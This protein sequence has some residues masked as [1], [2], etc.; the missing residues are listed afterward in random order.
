[1]YY[2]NFFIVYCIHLLYYMCTLLHCLQYTMVLHSLFV[3]YQILQ[4]ILYTFT[5]FNIC[6]VSSFAL[7]T[8][9]INCL[10]F[11]HYYNVCSIQWYF[12]PYVYVVYLCIVY[13]RMNC[14]VGFGPA[15]ASSCVPQTSRN[16][17]N[18]GLAKLYLDTT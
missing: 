3:R 9:Y 14:N 15:T 18:P 8:V 13:C 6:T 7:Y 1:M 11:L 10:Q 17:L 4:C 16:G 12:N 5:V 2:I